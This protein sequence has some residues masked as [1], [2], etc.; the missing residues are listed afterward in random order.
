MTMIYL[1]IFDL[2]QSLVGSQLENESL[3]R[4]NLVVDGF[5]DLFRIDLVAQS[6]KDSGQR[7]LGSL[8]DL[9]NGKEQISPSKLGPNRQLTTRK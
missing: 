8:H 1:T 4:A 2:V 5:F 6:L 9:E 3:N 7:L